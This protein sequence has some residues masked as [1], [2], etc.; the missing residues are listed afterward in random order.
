MPGMHQAS[1]DGQQD[2]MPSLH[3]ST[4]PVPVGNSPYT[5]LHRINPGLSDP[6]MRNAINH[7]LSL[8]DLVCYMCP[9]FSS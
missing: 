3:R 8:L 6:E 4:K 5:F 2:S 7:S 1:D 9:Y